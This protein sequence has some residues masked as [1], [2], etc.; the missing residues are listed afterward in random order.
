MSAEEHIKALN[1]QQPISESKVK[2]GRG[3]GPTACRMQKFGSMTIPPQLFARPLTLEARG[4]DAK[5]L[6]MSLPVNQCS[7][8]QGV[9]I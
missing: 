3:K 7:E 5:T 2:E 8:G 1:P 6:L 4:I 9:A